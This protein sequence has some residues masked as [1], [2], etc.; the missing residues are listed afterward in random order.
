M[1]ILLVLYTVG[2]VI[3]AIASAV[4]VR[5]IILSGLILSPTGVL[6][7]LASFRV[8]RPFGFHYGLTAPTMTAICACTIWGLEWSPDIAYLPIAVLLVVVA[9]GCVRVGW[10]AVGE[11]HREF[12]RNPLRFQF[13]IASLLWA[14][15]V[16][17]LF[18][19]F[20]RMGSQRGMAVVILVAYG[21]II[22]SSVRRFR[23]ACAS[24]MQT[25]PKV[26]VPEQMV[27]SL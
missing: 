15:L 6:I 24:E 5:S 9:L 16:V 7:A 4:N 8:G 14:M 26:N 18:F 17:A 1:R 11:C 19:G 20:L 3:A 22:W 21:A 25:A 2:F 27:D 13:S 12:A 10:L 23:R